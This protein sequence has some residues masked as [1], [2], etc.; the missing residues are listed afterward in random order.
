MPSR[1]PRPSGRS[2]WRTTAQLVDSLLDRHVQ[3]DDDQRVS[4]PTPIPCSGTSRPDC[5]SPST[6]RRSTSATPTAP[7]PC[8]TPARTRS[9]PNVTLP[10]STTPTSLAVDTANGTVY[11]SDGP[12]TTGS[13]TSVCANLPERAAFTSGCSATPARWPS[14]ETRE[15]RRRRRRRKPL[16]ANAGTSGSSTGRRL[17]RQPDHARRHDHHLDEPARQRHRPRS[18]RWRCH[19]TGTRS[20]QSSTAS[21]SPGRHGDYRSDLP[22]DL[23][24]GQPADWTDAMGALAG[25][26]ARDYVWVSDETAKADDVVQNLNLA[27]SDPASQPYV[28]SVGGTSVTALGRRPPRA[29]GTTG[30]TTRG[31]RR[32]RDP[33]SLPHADVPDCARHRLGEQRTPCGD[34]TGDCREVPDVSAD[35]DPSTGYVVYD[36]VNGLGFTAIGGTTARLRCGRPC[37]PWPHPATATRRLRRDGP[38]PLDL[39]QRRPA[40]TSTTS[41]PEKR[42][43]RHERGTDSAAGPGTTWRPGSA[44]RSRRR[45]ASGSSEPRST[46]PSPGPRSTEEPRASGQ[47]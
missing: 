12:R 31:R 14:A 27:V 4:S 34:T 10:S 39:A 1:W 19:R 8:T 20:W 45:S 29:P 26:S 18:A 3:P 16:V 2:S 25:D 28:T 47:R 42:L 33:P 36:S 17:C 35:A 9:S 46:W 11:L 43:Q 7:W 23:R 15:P 22:D 30:S 6:A 41:R 32:G 13:S 24:H 44:R 37:W 38:D 40:P 21:G 5:R